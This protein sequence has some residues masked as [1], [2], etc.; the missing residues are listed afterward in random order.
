ME[1]LN[2]AWQAASE[3]MYAQGGGDG[4][5]QQAPGQDQGQQQ[6]NDSNV[7]DAEYEEVK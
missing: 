6:G 4:A 1:T 2:A 5:Q 7:A 3:H